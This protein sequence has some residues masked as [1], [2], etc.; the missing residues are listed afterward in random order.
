MTEL[1]RTLGNQAAEVWKIGA[2]VRVTGEPKPAPRQADPAHK[3]RKPAPAADLTVKLPDGSTVRA[4]NK[5][6]AAAVRNALT[7][8]GVRYQ[9]G[10]K[11]PN[12][13]FDCSG[14]TQWA[15]HKAGKNIPRVSRDQDVGAR[16]S[17]RDVQPGDLAV[18][19]GHVAMIVGHG[20]MI[21]AGSPVELSHIRITNNGM[22]FRG[23]FRPT[24]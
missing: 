3:P 12:T 10:A 17:R 6:A 5:V 23:F 13:A 8:L 4:P 19:N 22:A 11:S 24:A 9:R 2:P 21:E 16:I 1:R 20:K 15:Y 7:Q 18:W 14:L